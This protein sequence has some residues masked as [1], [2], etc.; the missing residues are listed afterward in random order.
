MSEIKTRKQYSLLSFLCP[1]VQFI[2]VRNSIHSTL[3]FYLYFI[4]DVIDGRIM[5]QSTIKIKHKS[6]SGGGGIFH[7]SAGI[8]LRV[9]EAV[10]LH[11][12]N[13]VTFP[14]R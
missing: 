4:F 12:R 6:R 14:I 8:L 7:H 3:E 2:F 9:S 1:V 11:I 13:F 10:K 5:F